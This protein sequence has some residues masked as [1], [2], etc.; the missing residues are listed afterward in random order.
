DVGQ[1]PL[2]RAWS[3][4]LLLSRMRC[5]AGDPDDVEGCADASIRI[6]E[7]FGIK[8]EYA[9]EQGAFERTPAALDHR[10]RRTERAQVVH[11]R[12]GRLVAHDQTVEVRNRQG[13]ARALQERA[14]DAHI[15]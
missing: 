11:Q 9:L 15:Q 3:K 13:E 12:E 7:P 5:P 10:I 2:R 1:A 4:R 6:A 8:L 14:C